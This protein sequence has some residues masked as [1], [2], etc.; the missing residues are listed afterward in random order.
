MPR[1]RRLRPGPLGIALALWDV[2]R[3]LPPKQ[4]KQLLALARRHGP[5]VAA[6][7]FELRRNLKRR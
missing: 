7:A 3:R 4:R 1:L 6:K 5:K 2:Y